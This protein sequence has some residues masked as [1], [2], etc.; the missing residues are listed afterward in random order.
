MEPERDPE[1]VIDFLIYD[2]RRAAKSK[3]LPEI[4]S[5]AEKIS[6]LLA[7]V[8]ETYF[9][10]A[11]DTFN[12]LKNTWKSFPTEFS[13]GF[14]ELLHDF[15]LR[16]PHMKNWDV[17]RI[18]EMEYVHN[19]DV[20]VVWREHAQDDFYVEDTIESDL[21][22]M[23]AKSKRMD[24]VQQIR[25]FVNE[26]KI[27]S[28]IHF[29]PIDN[30]LNIAES[31]LLSIRELRSRG[32]VF[33]RNDTERFD[34]L[35]GWIST[36][37]SNPN[38]SYLH[39]IKARHSERKFAILE[40]DPKILYFLDWIGISTNASSRESRNQIISAPE[41]LV[42]VRGLKNLFKNGL[43]RGQ[44][45]SE[46]IRREAFNLNSNEPTDPQAEIMFH[47]AIPA[48]MIKA[49]HLEIPKS[50]FPFKDEEIRKIVKFLPSNIWD[51]G[52]VHFFNNPSNY[53]WQNR[54]IDPGRLE[55]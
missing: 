3:N 54:K 48:A 28:L 33:N 12:I 10:N 2:L 43:A 26:S 5:F 46:P 53:N 14:N 42:G 24:E 32:I 6:E 8:D 19:F 1:A 36:S 37:I 35:A 45:Q 55:N 20:E 13:I 34:G 44:A 40:L 50:Q 51:F 41:Q 7:L 23:L 49:I 38:Y 15:L 25:A 4:L 16:F 47:N 29:T 18:P 17:D 22:K 52:C 21:L 30:M 31:G 9:V 27:Q 11:Y 39:A